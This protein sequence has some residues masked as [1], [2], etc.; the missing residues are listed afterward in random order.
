MEDIRECLKCKFR[1]KCHP[2]VKYN[3]EY[4]KSHKNKEGDTKNGRS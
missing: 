3:S 2:V 1:D 4:C